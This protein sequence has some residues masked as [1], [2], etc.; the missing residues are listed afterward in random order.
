MI[1]IE[2]AGTPV[3]KGRP[4]FVR[5]TGCAYTPTKTRNYEGNLSLAA[6]DVMAGA[7]PLE[8][9]L[10]VVVRA[11]FPVPASWSRKKREAAL[12]S[13]GVYPTTKPD[14]DNLLKSSLDPLNQIVF[15]DDSQVVAAVVIK[16][17]SE[18]PALRIEVVEIA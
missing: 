10:A 6:Q 4:R 16:S 7:K 14:P 12:A 2:L 15:R 17:Y 8:G 9:P 11:L 5:R 1:V 13:S 18:R 3:G